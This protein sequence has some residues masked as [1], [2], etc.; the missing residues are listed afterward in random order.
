MRLATDQNRSLSVFDRERA[1]LRKKLCPALLPIIEQF[2]TSAKRINE[3]RIP[4]AG[5]LLAI[6]RQEVRPTRKKIPRDVFHDD[7]D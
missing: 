2:L 5:G 1:Q 3:F 4:M 7:G 6:R